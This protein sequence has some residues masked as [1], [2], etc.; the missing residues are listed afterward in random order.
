MNS[1]KFWEQV[2]FDGKCLIWTRG[3]GAKGYG[4]VTFG[5]GVRYA[6]RVAYEL[7]KGPIP[8][9]LQIDHLCRNRACV[10]PEHLEAVTPRENTIRGYA[11][12]RSTERAEARVRCK[13]NHPWQDLYISPDGRQHCRVCRAIRCAKHRG[14]KARYSSVSTDDLHQAADALQTHQATLI[15]PEKKP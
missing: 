2:V 3:R 5:G 4:G 12:K 14:K 8:P 13:N 7:V 6:H 9:G 10:N 15:T 1:L 11:G